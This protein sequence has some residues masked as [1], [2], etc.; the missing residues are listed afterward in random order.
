MAHIAGFV[1][2]SKSREETARFYQVLGL[3]TNEHAHGGPRHT[4]LVPMDRVV[5]CEIYASS[6]K[7][8]RDALMVYVQ[9]VEETIKKLERA[10]FPQRTDIVKQESSCFAYVYDPDERPVLLMQ[11]R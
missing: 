8:S 5:T 10:S 9:S 3:A 6:P 7:Y 2:R 1:L 4:E 11:K